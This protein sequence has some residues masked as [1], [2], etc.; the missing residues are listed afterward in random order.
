MTTL[1]FLLEEPSARAMLESFLPR[2]IPPEIQTQYAVFEGK[3]DLQKRLEKRLR[4]WQQ[5]DTRFIVVHDQ[6]S[7]DCLILKQ[8]LLQLCVRSGKSDETIVRI[9]CHELESWYL[10]DLAAVEIAL[11]ITGLARKQSAEKFRNPDRLANA[12]DELKKLTKNKYQKVSGSR[13]IGKYLSG[14]ENQSH[15]FQIFMLGLNRQCGV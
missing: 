2:L 8:A 15:S 4:E 13:E 6:D 10:G 9:P 3:R 1:L 11:G 5:P 14:Q 7:A 12:A